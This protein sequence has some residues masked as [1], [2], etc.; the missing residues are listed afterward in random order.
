MTD[1]DFLQRQAFEH[2]LVARGRE[3]TVRLADGTEFPEVDALVEDEEVGVVQTN[4]NRDEVPARLVRLFDT[5]V[6]LTGPLSGEHRLRLGPG[7]AILLDPGDGGDAV[8]WPVEKVERRFNCGFVELLC[9]RP[10]RIDSAG[11]T[12]RDGNRYSAGGRM[13]SRY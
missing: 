3:V 5:I 6:Y 7:A 1:H 10:T 13:R 8:E 9:A 4:G 2:E 11:R 12:N